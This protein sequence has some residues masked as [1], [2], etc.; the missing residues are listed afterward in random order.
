MQRIV[1]ML[2]FVPYLF[3]FFLCFRNLWAYAQIEAIP[4]SIQLKAVGNKEGLSQGFVPSI[5]QDHEGYMWFATKDGLNRYDGYQITVFRNDPSDSLSLGENEITQLTEDENGNLWIATLSKG[6]YVMNKERNE[7]YPLRLHGKETNGIA[8]MHSVKGWLLICT[9]QNLSVFDIRAVRS[10]QPSTL[11]APPPVLYRYNA[12]PHAPGMQIQDG[13]FDIRFFSD[14]SIWMAKKDTL[15]ILRRVASTDQWESQIIPA[16]SLNMLHQPIFHFNQIDRDSVLLVGTSQLTLF[17]ISKN[18]VVYS[19]PF[20][21]EATTP[22]NFYYARPAILNDEFTLFFTKK[23]AY[24]FNA[25]TLRY[26]SLQSKSSTGYLTGLTHTIDRDGNIWTGTSGHGVYTFDTRTLLFH[27]MNEDCYGFNEDANH[28]VYI[29]FRSGCQRFDPDNQS[30]SS[31]LPATLMNDDWKKNPPFIW[32][33]DTLGGVNW[34]WATSSHPNAITLLRHDLNHQTIQTFYGAYPPSY[35]SRFENIPYM[36]TDR[37]HDLWM[38]H[39]DT[40][41]V[42]FRVLD[43]HSVEEKAVYIIPHEIRNSQVPLVFHGVMEDEKG[44]LWFGSNRGLFRF[45]PALYPSPRAWKIYQ[46]ENQDSHSISG[47][48]ILC[49]TA[50]ATEPEN[51]LWIGTNG[52][53]LNKLNKKTGH[54]EHYNTRHGLANDVVYGVLTDEKNHLWISTNQGISCFDIPHSSFRNYTVEDGLSGNEFNS[55]Q[56]LKSG[57]GYMYFGGVDGIT[58]FKPKEIREHLLPENP[59]VFTHIEIQDEKKE[60]ET[61]E[62]KQVELQPEALHSITLKPDQKMLTIEFALLQFCLPEKKQYQYKL[63]G[64]NHSWIFIGNKHSITFTNLD[65]GEYTLLVKGSNSDGVWNAKPKQLIIIVETPWFKSWWFRIGSIGSILFL[66]YAFYRYRLKQE[67]KMLNMRHTIASDLHDDIGSTISSISVYSDILKENI[68]NP[69]MQRLAGRIHSSSAEILSS[70]SDIVW[71]INPKNDRFFSILNR[72]QT[73]SST[74]ADRQGSSIHF[75]TENI[76]PD[77]SMDMN[78]RKNV[79][80]FYK[81]ALINAIKHAEAKNIWIR[82]RMEHQQFILIVQDDG[83]G[84]DKQK[85]EDGNGLSNLRLRTKELAGVCS[86]ESTPNKGTLVTLRFPM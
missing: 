43:A 14:Q 52:S 15:Q 38:L 81:E 40:H 39:L 64:F 59:L 60:P 28:Q 9:G 62:G 51:F 82:I 7:F 83:K 50:D 79:Y 41:Q 76:N 17:S 44:I 71:S 80:L 86:I 16:A 26:Q 18:K 11:S 19:F 78:R 58:W 29:Y 31:I 73:L 5:L 32:C 65:P 37:K 49:I 48:K 61:E 33:T 75:E 20:Q 77:W 6:I 27:T 56:F 36:F 84:F 67:V 22:E 45:N 68:E 53:G 4:A 47:D 2:R 24:L 23:N 85:P 70:V 21:Q 10:S 46:H 25:K 35:Y 3:L 63:E 57:K 55:N 30:K 12:V 34:L 69:E 72:M 66:L 13:W 1:Y 54:F 74:F 42:A 8:Y